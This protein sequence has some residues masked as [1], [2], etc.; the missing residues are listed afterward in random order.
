MIKLTEIYLSETDLLGQS[1]F[2]HRTLVTKT[3]AANKA[4]RDGLLRT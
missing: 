3:K 4:R 2:D 1:V